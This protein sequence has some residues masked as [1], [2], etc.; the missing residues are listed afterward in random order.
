MISLMCDRMVD[1][2]HEI[3]FVCCACDT[4]SMVEG[5]SGQEIELIGCRP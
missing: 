5:S 3:E 2:R 1:G 4:S